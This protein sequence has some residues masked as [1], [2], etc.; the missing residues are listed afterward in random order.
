MAPGRKR[1]PTKAPLVAGQQPPLFVVPGDGMHAHPGK[2][3]APQMGS[4]VGSRSPMKHPR[5]A[6]FSGTN[7]S[8]RG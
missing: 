7:A 8:N 6:D 5:P 3:G 1:G 2:R 4:A